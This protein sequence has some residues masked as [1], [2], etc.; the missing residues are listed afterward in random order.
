M[1]NPLT[2]KKFR[3]LLLFVFI[4]NCINVKGFSE[5]IKLYDPIALYLTWQRQPETTMTISWITDLDR[6]SDLVE[7]RRS[8]KEKWTSVL[9]EHR[10]LPENTPYLLHRVEIAGLYPHTIYEFRLGNN[11]VIY[12]FQTM[13]ADLTNPIRFIAGGDMYHDGLDILHQTNQQA[14]KTAPMFALVGGD[15]AYASDTLLEFLPRWMHPF[16]DHFI[17][18]KFDRWLSWLVAWKEDMVRPDGCLIPMLP[19]IGNH[20]TIGRYGQTPDQAPFFY[21]LFPMPGIPGYNVL[22]FSNYMSIFI[23][24]SGHTNAI[25]G[26]QSDWLKWNLQHRMNIPH[27]FALYHVPA[28]PSVHRLNKEISTEIRKSWVPSFDAYRL[29]AAFENH[30][31]AYKRTHLIRNGAVSAYGVMYIGDGGWGVAHPRR[32]RHVS[33]KWYL[34]KAESTRHFLVIDVEENRQTAHAINSEGNVIDSFSW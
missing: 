12:K 5:E 15:I 6:K 3:H 30:E 4:I 23:L 34:A 27:K 22:D 11:A 9:G 13:P 33:D 26:K 28:Y 19:A 20:D 24:D 14:A 31:H 8:E 21:T 7:Y 25:S 1:V 18:Q 10:R 17:R 2:H 29:T 32:P 16:I